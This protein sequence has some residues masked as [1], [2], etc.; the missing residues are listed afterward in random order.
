[1]SVYF[2]GIWLEVCHIRVRKQKNV[3]VVDETE[4]GKSNDEGRLVSLATNGVDY[5]TRETRKE[6]ER[7]KS[8]R[9]WR[10]RRTAKREL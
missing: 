2:N 4:E 7:E 8:E 1:M 6:R 3:E 10:I 9:E 5:K